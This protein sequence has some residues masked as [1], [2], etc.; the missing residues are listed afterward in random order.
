MLHLIFQLPLDAVILERTGA[1]DALVLM[2][3]A[4]TGAVRQGALAQK[5]ALSAKSRSVSVL[6]DDIAI[7]GISLDR[8]VD[9]ITVIDYSGLV[10][11]VVAHDRVQ[12][13]S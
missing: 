5:L 7:R 1:G 11:A 2:G 8:L 13:W 10:A 9:G 3:H 12:T 4:V 6:A